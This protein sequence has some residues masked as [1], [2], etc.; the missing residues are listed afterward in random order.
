MD[1]TLQK[2]GYSR[3]DRQSFGRIFREDKGSLIAIPEGTMARSDRSAARFGVTW[4]N[5]LAA[6][7]KKRGVKFLPAQVVRRG[8][9]TAK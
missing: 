7:L 4:R 3:R 6:E 9:A 1:T 5:V 8:I 2:L